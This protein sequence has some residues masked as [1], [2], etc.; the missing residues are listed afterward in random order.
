MATKPQI[1]RLLQAYLDGELSPSEKVIFERECAASPELARRVDEARDV[2]AKLY[3]S[4][5]THR[6]GRDLSPAVMAHL[7]EMDGNGSYLRQ[8]RA[9]ETTW[10]TKHPRGG[11]RWFFTVVPA[12]SPVALLVLGFVI[13]QAWPR[14]DAGQ[15]RVVGMLTSVTGG[16]TLHDGGMGGA[17]EAALLAQVRAGDLVETREDARM[18]L[19]LSGPTYLKASADAR[20][21]VLGPREVRVEKGQV[22]LN[23][24]KHAER[25]RVRTSMGD[26]TVFGTVFSVEAQPNHVTVTLRD[27]EVT[28]EN[29]VDFAVLYPGE[30]AVMH[31]SGGEIEKHEVDAGTLL[32]WADGI[33]ADPAAR[34]E[35]ASSVGKLSDGLVRAEQVWWVDT[36]DRGPVRAM[37]F[38]WESDAT[39]LLPVSYDVLVYNENMQPL[40]SRRL[41]GALLRDGQKQQVELP[42]PE[43]KSLGGKTTFVRLVPDE[44]TGEVEVAFKEV[45]LIGATAPAAQ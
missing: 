13:F 6:L 36:R 19:A 30:Q 14:P 45:S 32:A 29:G 10:R 41:E 25:F 18:L 5:G 21:K 22:W 8:E 12:L 2:A 9:R 24:A 42:I 39:G 27:G 31:Q 44:G 43:G 3:E 11:A 7:P 15:P 38:T 23:V 4:L 26:V 16:V 37:A 17:R 35:F 40:F 34:A 33:E 28:V 20:F 1:E